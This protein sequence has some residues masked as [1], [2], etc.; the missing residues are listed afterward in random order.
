[1]LRHYDTPEDASR[2]LKIWK[3]FSFDEENYLS[4]ED[5]VAAIQN[6]PKQTL[7]VP[8]E[9]FK[10]CFRVRVPFLPVHCTPFN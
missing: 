1:M 4:A 5:V 7:V 8:Y 9:A 6:D 2:A 10:G 3:R